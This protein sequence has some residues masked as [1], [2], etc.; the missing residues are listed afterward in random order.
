MTLRLPG[1]LLLITAV[2]TRLA[3]S[4]TLYNNDFF[5][6]ITKEEVNKVWNNDVDPSSFITDSFSCEVVQK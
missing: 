2:C 3:L 5:T 4:S 1:A 6:R